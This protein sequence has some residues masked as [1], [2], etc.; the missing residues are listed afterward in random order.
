[1]IKEIIRKELLVNIFS[2]RFLIGLVVVMVMMGIVGYVLV[3]DYV[4]RNQTYIS[5]VQ[6]HADQLKNFKVYSTVQTVVDLS[7][8]PLSVFCRGANDVPTSIDIS[9]YQIPSVVD[10]QGTADFIG[11]G[12]ESNRPYN[13]FLRIFTPIDLAFVIGILLS[14]FAILLVFDSFS[15]EREQGTLRLMLSTSIGRM[16]VLLGKFIGALITM[17][18]PLTIGFIEIL[19]IWN[20]FPDIS[21]SSD[22]LFGTI[23][24][25]FFSLVF[26]AGFLALGLLISLFTRESS[27][28]L[29]YLL[30]TWVLVAVVIP[31][32]IG[33]L[34]EYNFPKES[35]KDLLST[36]DKQYREAVKKVP[37]PQNMMM[38]GSMD[39][40]G[41]EEIL[42]IN[43][44]AIEP[45][46]EYHK[47]TYSLKLQRAE[48]R[49]R[50]MENYAGRLD[51]WKNTRDALLRTSLYVMYKNI[52]T[53]ISGTGIET[54][55]T[56][57]QRVKRYR[58]SLVEYLR[59]KV[60]SAQWFTRVREHPEMLMT[61]ENEKKW[62]ELKK[63]EGAE[64]LFKIFT[65]D[66][67]AP[68]NV[69]DMP[70][71]NIEFPGIA[72]RLSSVMVD[73]AIIFLTTIA[74]LLLA[75]WRAA[76]YK[77]N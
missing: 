64:A 10:N 33:Y 13:P 9:S 46:V 40:E 34:A 37:Q 53:A 19:L 4:F 68:L 52:V 22:I 16:Q 67:I 27:T 17:A 32:G 39:Y 7:P 25:Y 54:Y 42:G 59:P 72:E 58:E 11:G 66:R 5:N 63:K 51:D 56:T 74:F 29:M 61:K 60:A 36:V 38:W 73:I 21:L 6:R 49:N 28:G 50:V 20:F 47:A 23:L 41:G 15:S 3:E 55:E 30:L 35:T 24:I 12:G 1:M 18:I 70:L 8:S 71:P 76:Y 69:N 31:D 14:L 75:C 26:L 62:D 77:V 48:D 57:I 43:P 65:W 2:Y 44:E 45:R